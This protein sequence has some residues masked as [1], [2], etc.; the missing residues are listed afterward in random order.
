ML[1]LSEKEI[2][3]KP[4]LEKIYFFK[5]KQKINN[6]KKILYYFLIFVLF[7]IGVIIIIIIIQIK[8]TNQFFIKSVY[9]KSISKLINDTY[10]KISYLEKEIVKINE[11][12]YYLSSRNKN[13]SNKININE[14]KD[15]NIIFT[16]GINDKYIKLQN[17]FCDNP[18]IFY[19]RIIEDKIQLV[20]IKFRDKNFNMFVYRKLD[21]VSKKIINSKVWEWAETSKLIIALNYYSNKKNIKKEDIYIIDAG[22]NIGW[23]SFILGKYGYKIISFEP[24]EINSYI[25]KKN[26]CLNKEINLTI[27]NKGLYTEEKK[28]ILYNRERN[29]GTGYVNCEQ[30]HKPLNSF[31]KKEEIILTKLSNYVQFFNKKHL[32][33]IK[34]DI[35]G[36]E[37]KAIESG[38][39]LIT[40]YHVP[41]IFFEFAPKYLK[42]HGTDPKDFLQLFVDNGYI[43]STK[44]FFNSYISVDEILKKNYNQ[45]NLYLMNSLILE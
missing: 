5:N 8:Y 44:D 41:F 15:G 6:L 27:I 21:I 36:S 16:E 14:N 4:Q 37:G 2:I 9:K 22:A 19:N 45:K 31:K 35:E 20:D 42:T 30:N 23:Y 12:I 17:Y 34:M 18:K 13:L 40:N 39:E 33:L 1:K 11:K 24:S 3:L 43:I 28:C 10:Y 7:I 25:L 38:I 29:E 32:V 26:Y